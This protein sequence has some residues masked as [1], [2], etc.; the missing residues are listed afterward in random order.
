MQWWE[1]ALPFRNAAAD[2]TEI[3][4][5]T[6]Q[7]RNLPWVNSLFIP[8]LQ[9]ARRLSWVTNQSPFSTTQFLSWRSNEWNVPSLCVATQHARRDSL[10]LPQFN[11]PI[12]HLSLEYKETCN[13]D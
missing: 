2:R 11:R 13:D 5:Q 6:G 9:S 12:S 7:H 4:A 8:R 10:R 3:S 1:G